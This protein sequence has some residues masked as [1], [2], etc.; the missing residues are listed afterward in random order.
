MDSNTEPHVRQTLQR[1]MQIP[2]LLSVVAAVLHGRWGN[3][4]TYMG[5]SVAIFA[6]ALV[7]IMALRRGAPLRNVGLP[8]CGF[9]ILLHFSYALRPEAILMNPMLISIAPLATVT[10]GTTAGIVWLLISM[11]Y[12]GG[13][14]FLHQWVL[15][16]ED[17]INYAVVTS[18]SMAMVTALVISYQRAAEARE[19][20]L[21]QAQ[22]QAEAAHQSRAAML[23]AVS[24]ELNTP[25]NGILGLARILRD[26]TDRGRRE[27]IVDEIDSNGQVLLS[28]FEAILTV[29]R[30]PAQDGP[31]TPTPA[32]IRTLCDGVIRA[33]QPAA[34]QKALPLSFVVDPDVPAQVFVDA[35][36][37]RQ[38]LIQLLS[39]AIKFTDT[40]TVRLRVH[41]DAADASFTLRFSVHDTGIGISPEDTARILQ[42]FSQADIG[43]T[44]RFEGLGLGLTISKRL[45][46]SMGGTLALESHPGEGSVFTVSLGVAVCAPPTQPV[47]LSARSALV[48]DDNAL[49]R[50]V[51][52]RTLE[53]LGCHVDEA[54]DGQEAIEVVDAHDFVMMDYHMPRLDGVEATQRLRDGGFDAPIIGLTADLNPD[55]HQRCL[56]AG[57]NR[58]LTK[59]VNAD[60]IIEELSTLLAPSVTDRR[61]RA[62][63]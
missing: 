42:P 2:L 50:L 16:S 36:R 43:S 38:V 7:T 58:C 23:S 29:A 49:N 13:L 39:N 20:S 47:L 31:A 59:P 46:Q 15:P 11:V 3:P 52:R 44:R 6:A 53:A 24:H 48:V 21:T 14:M 8:L 55:A 33:A 57:M 45:L 28:M 1:L 60:R 37:L 40:G 61:Q 19:Q 41:G 12:L 9:L 17:I 54:K 26:E 63:A 62:G 35:D 5:M 4:D 32:T 30:D 10:A 18:T 25:L 22:Q 34:D 51:C 27:E 56:L